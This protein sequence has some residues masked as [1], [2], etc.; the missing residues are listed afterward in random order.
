MFFSSEERAAA[1]AI[2]TLFFPIFLV[3]FFVGLVVNFLFSQIC[4]LFVILEWVLILYELL[5][6]LLVLILL[7]LILII[8]Y[9]SSVAQTLNQ[10]ATNRTGVWTSHPSG[11]ALPRNL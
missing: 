9:R 7:S 4:C 3:C 5:G 8:L 10:C 1:C 6:A 2:A 11:P